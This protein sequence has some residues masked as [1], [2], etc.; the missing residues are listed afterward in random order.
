M[1]RRQFFVLLLSVVFGD[2]LW[3][4]FKSWRAQQSRDRNAILAAWVDRNV[5]NYYDTHVFHAPDWMAL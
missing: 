3:A 5:W 1:S 4:R 2:Q